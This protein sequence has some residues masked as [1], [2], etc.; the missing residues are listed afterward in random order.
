VR[1]AFAALVAGLATALALAVAGH[2]GSSAAA[3]TAQAQTRPNVLVFETDDQTQA[4]MF[5][6]PN[7]QALIGAQGVTF[8]NS[9]VNFSLCCPSRSTFLRGQYSHNTGVRGNEAPQGGFDRLDSSN[10]LAVWLQR[11]GYYTGLIGKYLN[12]YEVHRNDPGG[13]LI[14]A[15]YSEWR[16]STN[17]YNYYGYE[18]N[19]GGVLTTYGSLNADPDAPGN[20]ANYQT[21]VYMAKAVDFVNRRAPS[22][23]PFFLWLTPLAPHNGGP[24]P[25]GSH[26]EGSA[27]PAP[28]D[29]HHFDGEP[30]P[31]PASFDEADVSDKP[32]TIRTA[33]A[34]SA[35]D[36]SD[37]T[38]YYR[39]RLD[40]L[41]AEDLGV[42]QVV[43]ALSASGELD[44][45]LVIFTSDNGFMHGEHRVK[46]GKVVPYEESIR[47]PL[48]IRGP[49]FPAGKTVR[50]KSINA[51][52][53]PTILEAT[54]ALAGVRGD[55]MPL[56]DLAAAP[57]R[58]LG[59]EL[60]IE[61][62]QYAGVRTDRYIY[63]EYTGGTNSGFVE[64]Y[65]L[66]ADPLEL[67]N[68]AANPAYATVRAALARRLAVVRNC[69]GDECRLAPEVRIKLRGRHGPRGCWRRPIRARIKNSDTSNIVLTQY[70]LNG[71]A[72]GNDRKRPFQ[73]KLPGRRLR[74]KR[75]SKARVLVTLLD[76]RRVTIYK[77]VR[78]CR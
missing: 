14:P 65:D 11:A 61:T 20:P 48:L 17:T 19:E 49:G 51:D 45:T 6:M 75:I 35:D 60:S 28:R 30:L 77:N 27:K 39:C 3:A 46:T 63:I 16:G 71:K 47:V 50:E 21:D 38:R 69:A 56:Q 7:T 9:F 76:G 24:N 29:L 36:I 57:G 62:N 18:L 58:E 42:Q 54:G 66:E 32:P 34:F 59:R 68:A 12:G 70:F 55:G 33:P 4:A 72:V 22:Q 23:Q 37:I 13:P 67:Q 2:G 78:A 64:M 74:N 8:P 44:N 25:A 31:R 73:R 5:A 1:L 53:A 15:G 43:G 40:S 41:L 10:T 26:C 52:L